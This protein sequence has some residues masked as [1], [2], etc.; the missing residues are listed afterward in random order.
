[1]SH[2][3]LISSTSSHST[4]LPPSHHLYC[5][6]FYHYIC[7]IEF[8]SSLSL[9]LSHSASV[10]V[11]NSFFF[12]ISVY[13][14]PSTTFLLIAFSYQLLLLL[15]QF[16]KKGLY[17]DAVLAAQ[18]SLLTTVCPAISPFIVRLKYTPAHTCSNL[19]FYLSSRLYHSHDTSVLFNFFPILRSFLF[20]HSS[21][22]TTKMST[23][24]G[25][26]KQTKVYL[27]QRAE[28]SML[29]GL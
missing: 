28:L 5:C 20:H 21:F 6:S 7:F 15:S 23:H 25:K 2:Y 17:S 24:N 4:L 26:A 3:N 9:P 19:S 18:S 16:Y 29:I 22:R 13:T 14:I 12:L 27:I 10:S 8:V 1:M 11:N